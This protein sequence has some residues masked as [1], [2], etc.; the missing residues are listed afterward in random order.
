MKSGFT[1]LPMLFLIMSA[2]VVVGGLILFSGR[3]T[4]RNTTLVIQSYQANGFLNAC[5]E[6]ALL[7]IQSGD[8]LGGSAS[9][10]P[11]NSLSVVSDPTDPPGTF[12]DWVNSGNA[13]ANDG[14][15]AST[16][17]YSKY[18]TATNFGF[19][20]PGT[21]TINGIE[22]TVKKNIINGDTFDL[23]A[24]LYDDTGVPAGDEKAKSG[25]W[26]TV[27]TSVI[28]G[29]ATDLWG[30]SLTPAIVN[31]V[32]FGFGIAVNVVTA[33]PDPDPPTPE[34]LVD[35]IAIKIYYTN[36][37]GSASGCLTFSQGNCCYNIQSLAGETKKINVTST[38]Q[39]IIR[40]A[41]LTVSSTTPKIS[42]TEW[43]EVAD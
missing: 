27:S 2:A 28:Y 19:S 21:A 39:S 30:L 3:T 26:P 15:N 8:S 17:G 7:Q 38:V 24:K 14:V 10:G 31:N 36:V 5:I 22:V 23:S 16:P 11:Q 13:M 33:E 35:W 25:N 4:V 1:L 40:K 29:G 6:E 12:N 42:I 37:S 9:I 34:V 43:Q 41:K 18:L 20:I 32:N